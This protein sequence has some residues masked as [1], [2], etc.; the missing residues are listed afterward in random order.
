MSDS[1][2]QDFLKQKYSVRAS[3]ICTIEH[4]YIS[5]VADEQDPKVMWIKLAD[6]YK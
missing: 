2:Y 1:A 6:A 3:T 5:I 4:K